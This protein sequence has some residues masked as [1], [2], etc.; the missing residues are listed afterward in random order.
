MH[1]RAMS[2]LKKSQG[3]AVVE[4]APIARLLTTLDEDAE[5][6]LKRKFEI[7]YFICKQKL[8]FAKMGPLCALEEKHGVDLGSG[9]KND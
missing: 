8:S 3:A 2:L 5:S 6:K 9:H 4:Y 1:R 7:A